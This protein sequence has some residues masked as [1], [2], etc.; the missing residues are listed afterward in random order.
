MKGPFH[1][2]ILQCADS[3]L[4]VGCTNDLERRLKQHNNEKSGA[5]YTKMRRPVM[6][7]HKEE[8]ETLSEGR[9][10]EAQIKSWRRKKKLHLISQ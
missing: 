1:V 9:K 6:L 5:H 7:V 8:F 2:Y 4:Y 3:S 10:R